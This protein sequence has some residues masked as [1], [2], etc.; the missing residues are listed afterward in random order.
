MGRQSRFP[1]PWSLQPLAAHDCC[2]AS[3]GLRLDNVNSICRPGAV[4]AALRQAA[5]PTAGRGQRVG[6]RHCSLLSTLLHASESTMAAPTGLCRSAP[7]QRRD[8]DGLQRYDSCCDALSA[9]WVRSGYACTPQLKRC[10]TD[11]HTHSTSSG[12]FS[13]MDHVCRRVAC[14]GGERHFPDTCVEGEAFVG[15]ARY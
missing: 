13:D 9:T 2:A 8:D 7:G 1:R 11:S 4:H 5:R 6:L 12:P 15:G 10:A 14:G 3:P